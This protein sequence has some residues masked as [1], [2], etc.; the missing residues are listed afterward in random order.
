M[1]AKDFDPEEEGSVEISP[2]GDAGVEAE[3]VRL[4]SKSFRK[5][6]TTMV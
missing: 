3:A 1:G 4:F 5:N 6:L 2:S